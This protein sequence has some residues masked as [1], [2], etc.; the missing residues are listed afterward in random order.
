LPRAFYRALDKVFAES[1]HGSRQRKVIITAPVPAAH[2]LPS[3]MLETFGKDFFYFF[4]KILCRSP[5]QGG[6]RQSFFYFFHNFFAECPAWSA[7]GKDFFYFFKIFA[8]CHCP[9]TPMSQLARNILNFLPQPLH[10]T[11]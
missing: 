6:A 10:E 3:A 1:N 9:G 4:K 5:Y 7:L 11:T 2:V 8:E